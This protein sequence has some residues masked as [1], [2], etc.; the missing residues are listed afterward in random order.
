M[1]FI[2]IL[3]L[4]PLIS[5]SNFNADS[6][7]ILNFYPNWSDWSNL[8]IKTSNKSDSLMF[9]IENRKNLKTS[10]I[11]EIVRIDTN[12][13][14][15]LVEF[16]NNYK[17]L[18]DTSNIMWDLSD[19]CDTVYILKDRTDN[20]KRLWIFG[21]Y[22]KN[23]EV[24]KFNFQKPIKEQDLKLMGLLIGLLKEYF[25]SPEIINYI[26]DIDIELTE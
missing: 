13:S 23:G 2:F 26:H 12:A 1:K 17:F 18:R 3:I 16:F 25:S 5:F 22:Y 20:K 24:K 8:T 21:E 4:F 9:Q 7:L 11:S 6:L 15:M 14:K 19:Y 10:F